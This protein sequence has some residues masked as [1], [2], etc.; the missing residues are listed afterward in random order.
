MIEKVVYNRTLDFFNQT[1]VLNDKQY[2]FCQKYSMYMA[3]L[4]TVNQISEAVDKEILL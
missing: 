4:E 2:V 3:L 1:H